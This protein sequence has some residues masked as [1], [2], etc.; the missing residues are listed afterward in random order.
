MDVVVRG[1]MLGWVWVVII[2]LRLG[3]WS[4]GVVDRRFAVNSCLGRQNRRL[5]RLLRL[6]R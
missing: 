2:R 6:V 4:S 3:E 1:E 5:N